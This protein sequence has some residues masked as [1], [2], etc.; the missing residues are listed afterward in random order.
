MKIIFMVNGKEKEVDAKTIN[1]AA[2]VK[3][4]LQEVALSKEEGVTQ[5]LENADKA[6]ILM[7]ETREL[8]EKETQQRHDLIQGLYKEFFPVYSSYVEFRQKNNITS[9]T[10]YESFSE[11][12][13]ICRNIHE[14]NLAIKW[15]KI[16]MEKAHTLIL[17]QYPALKPFCK[18]LEGIYKEIKK[19]LRIN[20]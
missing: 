1:S 11:E 5:I 9:M 17:K 14:K 10:P 2:D 15:H 13:N 4:V 3:R 19:G 6:A 12:I 16:K 8:R 20:G 18:A 7:K